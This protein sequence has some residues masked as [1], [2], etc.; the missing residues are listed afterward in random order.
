MTP[1]APHA[2][3]GLSPTPPAA[4]GTDAIH[5]GR[6]VAVCV[7]LAVFSCRAVSSLSIF[8]GWDMDPLLVPYVPNGLGPAVSLLCDALAILAALPLLWPRRGEA[9]HRS[10]LEL[11]AV[12]IGAAPILYHGWFKDGAAIGDQRIGAAWFSAVLCA[13]AVRRVASHAHVRAL[14]IGTLIGLAALMTCKGLV[15]VLVENPA[16]IADFRANQG[17]YLAAQGF[18]PDSP[19]A[20]AYI[21]RVESNDPTVWMGLTNIF[22]TFAA[23]ALSLACPLALGCAVRCGGERETGPRSGRLAAAVVALGAAGLLCA[24]GVLIAG[25]KGGFVAGLLAV[26]LAALGFTGL[27]RG[28]LAAAVGPALVAAALVAVVV[29]GFVGERLGELSLYFR[30]FYMKAAAVIGAANPLGV[31]PDGFKD[32][33]LLVKDPL[34]PEEVASPHSILLDWWACMGW[35]GV[36]WAALWVYWLVRASGHLHASPAAG[37]TSATQSLSGT[38]VSAAHAERTLIRAVAGVAVAATI[39]AMWTERFATSPEA[40]AVRV[41]GLFVWL[42][43]A[44][45]AAV[46]VLRA[47]PRI[48]RLA[49]AVAAIVA[50]VHSQIEMSST[51]VQSA[52]L[53]LLTLGAAASSPAGQ[54]HAASRPA[55]PWL[56]LPWLATAGVGLAVLGASLRASFGTVPLERAAAMLR[57][58]AE[59]AAD[60][61]APESRD[62]PRTRE[63]LRALAREWLGPDAPSFTDDPDHLFSRVQ[64]AAAVKAAATLSSIDADT[65]PQ[66]LDAARREASRLELAAGAPDRAAT[67]AQARTTGPRPRAEAFNWLAVV[68]QALADRLT[69]QPGALTHLASAESAL[70]RAIALDPTNPLHIHRLLRVQE[71]LGLGREELAATARRLLQLDDN[72]RL[73]RSVRGLG[74]AERRRVEALAAAVPAA[75]VP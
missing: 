62:L 43:L 40:A 19:M 69:A 68:H 3:P 75:P 4:A 10:A 15:Q 29:R 65:W 27:V 60:L 70:L 26:G 36:A 42:T 21:R 47:P 46:A 35:L 39:A 12:L 23:M 22:A 53:V 7:I 51:W 59:L 54:P 9:S 30:W 41:G 64:T 25:S 1:R 73:D 17:Q 71:R 32:A 6:L 18:S 24:V 13:L 49:L 67:I 66:G 31:G 45:V 2:V 20:K 28:K 44:C 8:P 61:H 50:C 5:A 11:L 48:A 33:Y 52:G 16:T 55:G 72:Q 37:A 63:R 38:V 34:S 56:Y 57:P 14:V 58:I 74:E